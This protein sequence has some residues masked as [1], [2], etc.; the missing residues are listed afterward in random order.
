[1]TKVQY[2]ENMFGYNEST[3]SD[4]FK[5]CD[6]SLAFYNTKI[7]TIVNKNSDLTDARIKELIT[8]F[9]CSSRT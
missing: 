7:S 3:S 8:K 4:N 6:G 2:D 1:M 9:S 5:N